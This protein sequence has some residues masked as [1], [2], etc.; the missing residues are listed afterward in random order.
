MKDEVWSP[1]VN[2][3]RACWKPGTRDWIPTC[4][5]GSLE[6]SSGLKNSRR[7]GR[8]LGFREIKRRSEDRTGRRLAFHVQ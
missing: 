6:G 8:E 4:W 1:S 7:A 2:W 3:I 5:I